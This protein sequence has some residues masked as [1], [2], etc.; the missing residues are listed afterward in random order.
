MTGLFM[1]DPRITKIAGLTQ[2]I[3]A[4]A[5]LE[6]EQREERARVAW[7][8][9]NDTSETVASIARKIGEPEIRF[10]KSINLH[11]PS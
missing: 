1:D 5:K 4:T 7:D 11:R 8:L 2:Q 10:R 9:I 3:E 6:R